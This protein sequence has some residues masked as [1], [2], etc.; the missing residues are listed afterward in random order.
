MSSR[1]QIIRSDLINYI[2]HNSAYY[3][4]QLKPSKPKINLRHMHS[5]GYNSNLT[6]NTVSSGNKCYMILKM[7]QRKKVYS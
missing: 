7:T 1:I 2:N 5:Q 6:E 3:D 4:A